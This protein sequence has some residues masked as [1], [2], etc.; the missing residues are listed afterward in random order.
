MPDD[1]IYKEV[2]YEAVFADLTT[3]EAARHEEQ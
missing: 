1:D 2:K 3:E